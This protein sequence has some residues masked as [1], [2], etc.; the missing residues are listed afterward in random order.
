ML[1]RASPG[2]KK[3]TIYEDFTQRANDPACIGAILARPAWSITDI[4]QGLSD[5]EFESFRSY[6]SKQ[7]N[8]DRLIEYVI[9]NDRDLKNVEVRGRVN[10]PV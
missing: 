3:R 8:M 2:G 7:K 6:T 9:A 10:F 5:Q 4:L 1:L